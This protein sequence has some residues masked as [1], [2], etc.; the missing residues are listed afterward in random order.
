MSSS[1]RLSLPSTLRASQPPPQPSRAASLGA[2]NGNGCSAP[3]SHGRQA[4][5][6]GSTGGSALSANCIECRYFS[7]AAFGEQEAILGECRRFPPSHR[8]KHGGE[9]GFFPFVGEADWCGEF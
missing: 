1:P 4:L 5:P 3:S 6:A 2:S 8:S 9:A 7:L